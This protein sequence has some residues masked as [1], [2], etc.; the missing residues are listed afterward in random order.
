MEKK[1]PRYMNDVPF[2]PKH[3]KHHIIPQCQ[4]EIYNVFA[5]INEKDV[6]R[7]QH[8][9]FHKFVWENPTPRKLFEISL[10]RTSQVIT[11]RAKLLLF[12]LINLT[13][14]EMYIQKVLK[15]KNL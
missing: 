11:E 4:R 14:E 9:W 12:E 10:E 1:I 13:D 6:R 5:R 3:D 7:C 2:E 15:D 8:I